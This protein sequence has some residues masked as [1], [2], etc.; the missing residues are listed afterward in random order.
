M[1]RKRVK[2]GKKNRWRGKFAECFAR[3]YFRLRGW[4]I[5]HK[6]YVT[7]RGTLSS[8]VDFIACRGETLAFVE[9][10]ER[11]T[12]ELAAYAIQPKQQQR[13]INAAK[14]FLAR[15]PKYQNHNIRFDAVLFKFPFRIKHIPNAW[16]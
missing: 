2:T 12:M 5:L 11:R 4:K 1:N 6:N 3:C 10:K 13:L 16:N 9:V 15:Y 14:Y 8:E 7:G